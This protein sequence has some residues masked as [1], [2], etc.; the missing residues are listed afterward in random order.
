MTKIYHMILCNSDIM[1]ILAI[2][3]SLPLNDCWLCAGTLRNFIWNKLSGINETLMLYFLI[4]IF[5]MKKR[6]Y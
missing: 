6:W 3:K 2:I 5:L 1:K 4:K